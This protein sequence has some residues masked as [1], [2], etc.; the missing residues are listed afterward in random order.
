ME[1]S[2]APKFDLSQV[3]YTHARL[4]EAEEI[5]KVVLDA[6]IIEVGNTGVAFKT[7]N[8][9]LSLDQVKEDIRI[10]TEI[11]EGKERPDQVYM[12]ARLGSDLTLPIVGCIRG[13]FLIDERDN[14]LVNEQGPIAIAPS[15][16]GKGLGTHMMAY[17]EDYGLRVHG[18]KHV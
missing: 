6:Y 12:V 2:E 14:I 15:M 10:S 16:Q 7:K 13:V 11:P 9:Y 17:C 5:M 4:D 1:Q 18:A 8:R 3:V